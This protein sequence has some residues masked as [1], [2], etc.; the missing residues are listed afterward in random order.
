VVELTQKENLFA[1]SIAKYK[2]EIESYRKERDE[3]HTKLE[4]I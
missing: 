3:V 4:I 2:C 1:Q